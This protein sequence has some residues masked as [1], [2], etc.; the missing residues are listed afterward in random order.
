[1]TLARGARLVRIKQEVL[2]A[3]IRRHP[4][5]LQVYLQQ[6]IARLWRVA[7]FVLVVRPG[8]YCS[9]RHRMPFTSINEGSKHVG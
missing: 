4:H 3:F 9:P 2:M 8:S 6:A 7:H 5:T 1:M